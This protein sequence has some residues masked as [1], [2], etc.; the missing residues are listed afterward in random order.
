M[1]LGFRLLTYFRPSVTV[2][3]FRAR[4][5]ADNRTRGVWPQNSGAADRSGETILECACVVEVNNEKLH[6]IFISQNGNFRRGL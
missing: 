2:A 3:N 1:S 5:L 4:A 6:V